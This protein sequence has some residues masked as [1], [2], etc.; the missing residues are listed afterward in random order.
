[1]SRRPLCLV[2]LLLMLGIA[3]A[4]WL[5]I[6][7]IWRSPAGTAPEEM[8]RRGET[9]Y[10]EGIVCHQEIKTFRN[11]TFTYL[12]LKQTNLFIHSKKFPIRNLKCMYEGECED[13]TGKLV[14]VTGRLTLPEA[15]TNPGQFDQRKYERARKIDYHMENIRLEGFLGEEGRGKNALRKLKK[16]CEDILEKIFPK[17]RAGVLEA[18]LLGEKGELESE[19][20]GWYQSAGISHIIAISGVCFLCWVFLIGERMA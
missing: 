16:S 4:N 14:G 12:Y 20:K 17:S 10:G 2:T 9:V 18:M 7:W 6:S 3:A 15:P 5:G 8:A 1:M 19:M 13:F 11:M